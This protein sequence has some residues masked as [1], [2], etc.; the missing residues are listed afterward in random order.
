[1]TQPHAS[2]SCLTVRDRQGHAWVDLTLGSTLP[3]GTAAEAYADIL[4]TVAPEW[5]AESSRLRAEA[6]T[7]NDW[8]A[9]HAAFQGFAA[10]RFVASADE[11]NELALWLARSSGTRDGYRVL[12]L[13]G[14]QHGGSLALRSA[15]GRPDWQSGDGPV[16]SGFKHVKPGSA[17]A[18][19]KAIDD[20]VAAVMLSPIDW[21][22]GGVPFDQAYLQEV[23]SICREK[24]VR[25]ILDET[26][27]APG[28]SGELG[29]WAQAGL[30]PD[31]L[32]VAAGWFYGLPGGALFSRMDH[33][34][35]IGR[36][37]ASSHDG[38]ISTLNAALSAMGC[39]SEQ[40]PVHNLAFRQM[41]A[42]MDRFFAANSQQS[43]LAQWAARLAELQAGFDF[44]REVAQRGWWTTLALD[45]P[46]AELVNTA[47]KIGLRLQATGD[48]TVLICP[49]LVIQPDEID[50]TVKLLRQTLELVES[51]STAET[52]P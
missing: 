19:E 27:T 24:S 5:T 10:A 51:A 45:L 18:I 8:L 32:T 9:K 50:Q 31:L 33:V 43:A 49:P 21:S 48:A 44:V 16:C 30:E 28:V 4:Q 41:A 6:D 15:S 17:T 46:A 3:F 39:F 37:R 52:L 29:F 23:Q 42:A 26:K 20:S 25:F 11:A 22:R 13:L 38:T 34:E 36:S 40:S 47:K 1:M 14:S 12:T 2:S 7:S 35:L